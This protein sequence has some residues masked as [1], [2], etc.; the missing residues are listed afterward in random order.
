MTC[1]SC[2]LRWKPRGAAHAAVVGPLTD[3]PL[4]TA[5]L[6]E[7]IDVYIAESPGGIPGR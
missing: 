2:C 1:E 3:D 5:G 7:M 4:V 6:L